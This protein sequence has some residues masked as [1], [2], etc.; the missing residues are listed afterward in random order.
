M[1]TV[2]HKFV[3]FMPDL[4]EEGILYISVEYCTAIHKCMCG[5]KEE[6]VT[7]IAPT[8]WKLFFDGQSVS[9]SPSIGNWRFDCKSHYLIVNNQ[10]KDANNWP[11]KNKRKKKRRNR[12]NHR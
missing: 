12:G 2:Q 4:I 6:V 11:D 9:L 10:I 3:E 1:K 7:P 5:C 8:G